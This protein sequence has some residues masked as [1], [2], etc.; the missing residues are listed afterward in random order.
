MFQNCYFLIELQFVRNTKLKS[1]NA[2]NE[3]DYTYGVFMKFFSN[4]PRNFSFDFL[5][6][7]ILID[8]FLAWIFHDSYLMAKY[9]NSCYESVQIFPHKPLLLPARKLSR[10]SRI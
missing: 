6:N 8:A 7:V 3:I 5:R 2:S 4:T 1:S 10:P 9:V